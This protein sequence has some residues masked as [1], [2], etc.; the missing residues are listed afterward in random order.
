M[1]GSYSEK[2]PLTTEGSELKQTRSPS[3]GFWCWE[4][5]ERVAV[6]LSFSHC[7][8]HRGVLSCGS[9]SIWKTTL[10]VTMHK[11][12]VCVCVC[13]F[14]DVIFKI[15]SSALSHSPLCNLSHHQITPNLPKHNYR[16]SL[17]WIYLCNYSAVLFHSSLTVSTN[18]YWHNET[19]FFL[20]N[21]EQLKRSHV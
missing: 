2:R 11:R 8:I 19:L 13:V 12:T 21:V 7:S 14:A 15:F 20:D 16:Q 1:K 6:N 4:V 17:R 18:Y 5:S 3:F 10:N 9:H